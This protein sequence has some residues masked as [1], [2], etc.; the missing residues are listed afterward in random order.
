MKISSSPCA[1]KLKF[2]RCTLYHRVSRL[3]IKI[4]IMGHWSSCRRFAKRNPKQRTGKVIIRGQ[5]D[6]DFTCHNRFDLAANVSLIRGISI[7]QCTLISGCIWNV[8]ARTCPNCQSKSPRGYTLRCISWHAYAAYQ[9]E[10]RV[11]GWVS[12]RSGRYIC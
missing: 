3:I 1:T 11:R 6:A 5:D 10:L 12:L 4:H 7:G 2:A 8:D 9:P